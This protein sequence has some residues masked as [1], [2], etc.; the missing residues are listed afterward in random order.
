MGVHHHVSLRGC[1]A[2]IAHTEK[3]FEYVHEALSSVLKVKV[4]GRLI[5]DGQMEFLGRLIRW[6][7]RQIMLE[8]RVCE[9][10]L[11]ILRM[12]H[13]YGESILDD[14]RHQEYVRR[15]KR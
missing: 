11:Y 10:G 9:V 12:G 4:T 14:T 6:D 1:F 3:G 13:I 7:G 2:H 8:A 5:E 15:E